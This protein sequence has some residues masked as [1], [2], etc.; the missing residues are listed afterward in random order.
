M[1]IKR[2]VSLSLLFT[3][4]CFITLAQEKEPVK[5]PIIEVSDV[6][7]SNKQNNTKNST[8]NFDTSQ[9]DKA[10]SSVSS[11]R[12]TGSTGD[13]SDIGTPANSPFQLNGDISGIVQNSINQVTGKVAF[14]VPLASVSSGS[15]SYSLNL[16]YNGQSGFKTGK[17]QNKFSPTSTIGVGWSMENPKIVVDNKQTA[18][19]DDDDFFIIDGS[20]RSELVCINRTSSLWEFKM[21][22]YAPWIIKYHKSYDYWSILKDDGKTYYYG[23]TNNTSAGSDIPNSTSKSKENVVAWG[24]WIGDSRRPNGTPNTIVWNISKIKDQWD[25]ELNFTYELQEVF[26]SGSIKQTEAAYLKEVTSTD[27]GRIVLDYGLKTISEYYEPHTEISE[28]DAYQERYEKKFL[29]NVKVYNNSNVLFSTYNIGHTLNG[30]SN[31]KKRY[32]TSITQKSHKNGQDYAL[33]SQTFEYHYSGTYKGGLKKVTYPSGGSATYNYENKYTFYNGANQ[34][35]TSPNWQGGYVF[36]A[37]MVKEN[38]HIYVRRTANPVSGS[39]WHQFIFYRYWW[40]GKEWES[41]EFVFPHLIRDGY[42]SPDKMVG[43]QPIF[44]DNFYGFTYNDDW[45]SHVYLFKKNEYNNEWGYFK[46]ENITIANNYGESQETRPRLLS[47]NDFAALALDVKNTIHTFT[48]TDTGWKER[49][50][51]QGSGKY[52]YA[53][54]NNFILSLDVE[55]GPDMVTGSNHADNY[56]IHYLDSRKRWNTKSW[57]AFANSRISN[58]GDNPE[59]LSAIYPSNGVAALVADNNPEYLLRWDSD[60]DLIAVDNNVLGTHPDEFP[61]QPVG[62]DFFTVYSSWYGMPKKSARFTGTNWITSSLPSSSNYYSKLNFGKDILMFQDHDSFN[63][64]GYHT[65]NPNT[66]TFS[67][68]LING[69]GIISNSKANGIAQN[70]II[71]GNKIYEKSTNGGSLFNQI[72]SLQYSNNFTYTDG[73]NHAFVKESELIGSGIHFRQGSYFYIN[74]ETGLLDKI[75]LNQYHL[76]G[77]STFAGNTPFMSTKSMWLRS[78]GVYDPEEGTTNFTPYVYR[79]IDDKFNQSIY[80]IV[81]NNIELNDNNG[82]I[83]KVKYTYNNPKSTTNNDAIYYGE[84]LS[85]NIGFG[86]NSIGYVKRTYDTGITDDRKTGLNLKEE[87]YDKNNILKKRLSNAW[88]IPTITHIPNPGAGITYHGNRGVQYYTALSNKTEQL[89]F[90][91]NINVRNTTTNYYNNNGQ[92]NLTRTYNSKGELES[93]EIKYA[94]EQYSFVKNANMLNHI[95]QVTTK[96]NNSVKSI[97]RVNWASSSGKIYVYE[98]WSGSNSSNLRLNSKITNVNSLGNIIENQNGTNIYTTV[99]TGYDDLYEVA[100][101]VNSRY[102]DVINELDVSFNSLQN[103]G[104]ENLKIELVKLYDRLPNAMIS[105]SFFDENGR[106]INTVNERKEESYMYYD[107]YGRLDYITDGY[108]NVLER[109]TYNYGN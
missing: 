99:L 86:S 81:V 109:K 21:K 92:L 14:S 2:L 32:L 89:I 26:Q 60:Y 9:S 48:I 45:K 22:K 8:N 55:G 47:G 76:T 58:I 44:Q 95:Y 10:R 23:F 50:I 73:L 7:L 83:R 108:G 63:G 69:Q 29:N 54:T 52:F 40:N 72:G 5:K 75:S 97:E 107:V 82:N 88:S 56:Y 28:P 91:N 106:V 100:T 68:G 90:A 59:D 35:K 18:T 31:N 27:G 71:A 33:P 11:N 84:V 15:I 104:T 105:L 41:H 39:D 36:Y 102:Q 34:Y 17:E 25:N 3:S 87:I 24:N 16:S 70:L 103:L 4:T 6:E 79:I 20:S 49:T 43:F 37:A 51:N 12:S 61:V 65:Y 80:N 57:S 98:N 30:P 96:L 64:V 1:N 53:G 62:N 42:Y 93:K 38:Y 66:Y 19:Q 85:E 77:T 74:R 67:S 78:E 13:G 46:K 94:H 101:I